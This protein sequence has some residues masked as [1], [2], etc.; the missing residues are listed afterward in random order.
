MEVYVSTQQDG[1]LK[2]DNSP[3]S[4][5]KRLISSISK[6]GRNITM[7]NWY[8]SIPLAIDLLENHKST[9]VETVMNK[10]IRTKKCQMSLLCEK[11]YVD[12]CF[13]GTIN[14]IRQYVENKK[15]WVSIDEKPDVGGSYV[16][17]VIVGTL[18]ISEPGKSFLLN[19]EVLEKA[20]N[21]TIAKLF[22]R[23]MGIIWPDG[24][25]HDNVLLFVS[26]AAPYTVKAGKNIKA[27]YSKM[28]HVTCLAHGLH[29]VAKKVKRRNSYQKAQHLMADKENEANLIFIKAN[30]GNIPSCI[31]R[32]EASGIPLVEAIGI[33]ISIGTRASF[34][35]TK[36]A[37]PHTNAST[38]KLRAA[39][40]CKTAPD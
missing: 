38:E 33:W 14:S 21:S 2:Y 27:L 18:E 3:S 6:T 16:A 28:E 37:Q 12:K 11:N 19:C 26:D 10:N 9:I 5:V 20:N 36:S 7:D 31:T 15:I 22:D 29:R 24:V 8:T 25:K 40:D 4:I 34:G 39:S 13:N 35:T 17:N 1:L 32:L 23:S 30:Y